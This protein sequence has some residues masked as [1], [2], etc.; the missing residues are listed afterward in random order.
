[1][2]L[3]HIVGVVSAL[4]IV[5][6]S[7]DRASDFNGSILPVVDAATPLALRAETL[8]Q[9]KI[10]L[11]D[12]SIM[13]E[14]DDAAVKDGIQYIFSTTF[15]N[16]SGKDVKGYIRSAIDVIDTRASTEGAGMASA[17]AALCSSGTAYTPAITLLPTLTN[18]TI[19]PACTKIF[20][21]GG[22]NLAGIG[23]G[24]S[25]GETTES[26]GKLSVTSWLTL[27]QSNS[28]DK[29]AMMGKIK[30][31]AAATDAEKEAEVMFLEAG[32]AD[33]QWMRHTLY[34]INAKPATNAFEFAVASTSKGVM[35]APTATSDVTGFGCG[36]QMVSDGTNIR[37][38]GTQNLASGICTNGGTAFDVCLKA[39]DLEVQADSVCAAMTFSMGAIDYTMFTDN[40]KAEMAAA[41]MVAAATSANTVE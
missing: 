11:S 5:G 12:I 37:V 31:A 25:Y 38:K 24:Y 3:L 9:Q 33:G 35:Q 41:L 6:C 23:S 36:M 14:G 21:V 28:I 10:N 22:G 34:R 1:M 18:I 26:D 2:K 19:N 16:I 7:E 40:T 30:N 32:P 4:G 39:G 29:F 15:P 8:A 27:V 17:N 13:A 20:A